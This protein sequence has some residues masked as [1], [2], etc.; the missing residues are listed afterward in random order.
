MADLTG[1]MGVPVIVV[2]GEI[3]IGFNRQRLEQLLAVEYVNQKISLG[4]TIADARTIINVAGNMPRYGVYVGD[5]KPLSLGDHAGLKAGDVI[6][7]L[8]MQSVN[9]SDDLEKY[10][11]NLKRGDRIPLTIFRQGSQLQLEIIN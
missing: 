7:E 8:N 11:S 4:I 10:L 6:T 3:I 5:V 1:Q 9:N 2:N